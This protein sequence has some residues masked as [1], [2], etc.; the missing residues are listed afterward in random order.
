[1]RLKEKL[2]KTL[3]GSMRVFLLSDGNAFSWAVEFNPDM[4]DEEDYLLED[5]LL[6]EALHEV[7][8]PLGSTVWISVSC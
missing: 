8:F 2:E 1:M 4:E 6:T 5:K 3:I 7:G